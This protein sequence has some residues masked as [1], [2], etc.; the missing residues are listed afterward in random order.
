MKGVIATIIMIGM[1]A[2]LLYTVVV[3]LSSSMKNA[4]NKA[5][6]TVKDFSNTIQP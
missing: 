3:P 1:V 4:G 5:V 2:A 6:N